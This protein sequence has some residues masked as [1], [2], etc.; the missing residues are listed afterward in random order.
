MIYRVA[1]RYFSVEGQSARSMIEALGSFEGFQALGDTPPGELVMRFETGHDL[2]VVLGKELYSLE[3]EGVISIFERYADG[4]QFRLVT[5]ATGDEFIFQK[6]DGE[7]IYRA[8][9]TAEP[10]IFRFA[11]W[12]A[13]NMALAP[14][15]VTAIHSSTIVWNDRAVMFLGES[16]TGKS[17]QTKLWLKHIENSWLLNDDSPFLA[18]EDGVCVAY[19]SPWSGKTPCY[20]DKR[21][22]VA[23]IVRL[24]QAPHNKLR[25]L[26]TIEAFGALFPSAPPALAYDPDYTD[27]TC[28]LISD[29]IGAAPLYHFECLPDRDAAMTVFNELF[30]G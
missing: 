5:R 18:V 21:V 11:L 22:P 7:D 30:G 4:Y 9:D 13:L 14:H 24:S 6:A 8:N 19:G 10:G 28:E 12:M 3:V 15:K 17:T 25:R 23:A 27:M 26:P 2:D 1:N 20:K 16:G 29:V